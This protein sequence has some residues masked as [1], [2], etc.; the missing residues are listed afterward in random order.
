MELTQE[1][2]QTTM[3]Y[4]SVTGKAIRQS[5]SKPMGTLTKLGYIRAY[6]CGKYYTLTHLIWL[7]MYGRFP[8]HGYII[9]HINGNTTDNRLTNLREVTQAVNTRNRAYHRNG[10]KLVGVSY[11]SRIDRYKARYT[12]HGKCVTIGYYQTQEEAHQAYTLY[13]ASME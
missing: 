4:N 8:K 11:E 9:D 3:V 5:N 10:S 12:K 6:A 2:I 1:Q 13:V 7:Y